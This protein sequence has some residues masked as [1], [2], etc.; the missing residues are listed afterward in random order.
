MMDF[1]TEWSSWVMVVLMIIIAVVINPW[2]TPLDWN[3]ASTISYIINMLA[4]PFIAI[5]VATIP[6]LIVCSLLKVTPDLD[7]SIRTA[8]GFLIFLLIQFLVF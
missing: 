1:R 6:V 4:Y 8:F 5:A 2:A 7:Y 3:F